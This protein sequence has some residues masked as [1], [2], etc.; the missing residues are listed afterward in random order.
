MLFPQLNEIR[1][2]YD[3]DGYW[4]FCCDNDYIKENKF[5]S[6]MKNPTIMSVPSS[7]NKLGL[8]KE[9]A[10]HIGLIVYEKEVYLKEEDSTIY[11]CAAT[12]N[13][14]VYLNGEH[15]G[16]HIGGFLPFEF[17]LDNK[18][19][20]QK[21]RIT[22][23]ID[24]QINTSTI[25][26]G[27]YKEFEMD[28]KIKKVISPGFDFYNFCGLTRSV[29]I[30][31]KPKECIEDVTVLSSNDGNVKISSKFNGDYDYIKHNI[32]LEGELIT[33]SKDDNFK[34]DKP[35]LWDCDNPNL[36]DIEIEYYKNET[37]IDKYSLRYGF[38]EIKVLDG[39]IYLNGK[40][41][42]FKGFGKHEDYLVSGRCGSDCQK[43]YDV[44]LMKWMNSN[45]V[46]TA[47][48]PHSEEFMQLCLENGILVINEVAA[49]GININFMPQDF[50]KHTNTNNTYESF[51]TFDVHKQQL[52]ELYQR[53]KNNAAVV[54][55][56]IANEPRT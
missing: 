32:F 11:F 53:D 54:M 35:K 51:D 2:Y 15:I 44:N 27:S 10:S 50:K 34:I 55:W 33:T 6:R 39:S 19:I 37:L 13:A 3:I 25:P 22:V 49:V 56:S 26:C 36:Y 43:L 4:D 14:D 18:L 1:E 42:Y 17:K 9:V 31:R 52:F 16:S 7:Y 38:R 23:V 47:H 29:Y 21:N 8:D 45:S 5:L 12:H 20:N 28:N 40:K 48:Y 30:V 46:R 41:V 24:T